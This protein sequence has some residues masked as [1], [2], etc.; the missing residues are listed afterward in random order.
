MLKNPVMNIRIRQER[1]GD[2]PVILGLVEAA[3][4]DVKESDHREQFLVERLHRSDA[5]VPQL[6]WVAETD[7]GRIVGY[8][9]LTKVEIV[10]EGSTAASLAV[11]P[12]AVLP[13]FQRRGVGGAL[14]V[15]VHTC[16]A[17]LGYG[18]AVLLGHKDYY[19][20]FGYRK[21]IDY[22]IRFPFD[23]PCESCMIIELRPRAAD[24]LRGTV[25]YPEAFF[26]K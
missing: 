6:S 25:R 12:L 1:E 13:G 20:R 22:G 4:A 10:S 18:T 8:V 21:A 24:G 17:S 19:P 9:L 26:E 2:L 11:A 7:G 3:F 23:A 15:Q 5:F 16:A 14:L